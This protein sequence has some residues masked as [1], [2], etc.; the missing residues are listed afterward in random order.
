MGRISPVAPPICG[1][2]RD[3]FSA[4]SRSLDATLSAASPSF[5]GVLDSAESLTCAA[6]GCS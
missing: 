2:H 1:T 4:P 3:E 6:N 5:R